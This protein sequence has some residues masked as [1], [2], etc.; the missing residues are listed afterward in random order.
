MKDPGAVP[1]DE[2]SRHAYEQLRHTVEFGHCVAQAA[3]VGLYILAGVPA[4]D[5]VPESKAE[6][7]QSAP[8]DEVV[9]DEMVDENDQ[10]SL[11]LFRK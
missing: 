8:E 2:G 6:V 3:D 5:S 4:N 7:P 1:V 9:E 10:F 11:N